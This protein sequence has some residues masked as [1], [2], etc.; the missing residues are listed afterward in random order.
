M[1]QLTDSSSSPALTFVLESDFFWE[2]RLLALNRALAPSGGCSLGAHVLG[3][4]PPL[5]LVACMWDPGTRTWPGLLGMPLAQL[6]FSRSL[7]CLS[8]FGWSWPLPSHHGDDLEGS[9]GGTVF[10][11]SSSY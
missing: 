10:T 6:T 2:V 1:W 11:V 5:P 9:T 3:T 8:A 4:A 7:L